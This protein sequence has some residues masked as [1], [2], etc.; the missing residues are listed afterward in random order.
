[1]ATLVS[2]DPKAGAE[3]ALQETISGPEKKSKC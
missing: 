3:K 2:D 1:M